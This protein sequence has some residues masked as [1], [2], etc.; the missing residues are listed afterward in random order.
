MSPRAVSLTVHTCTA[1]CAVSCV[2]LC[3]DLH[4]AWSTP[5]APEQCRTASAHVA[6][7]L[8]NASFPAENRERHCRYRRRDSVGI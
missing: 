6:L 3:R 7:M 8:S 2:W 5:Q 4:V 1:C